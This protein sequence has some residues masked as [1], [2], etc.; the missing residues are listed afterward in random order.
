M[1]VSR[2]WLSG[3][4]KSSR[5]TSNWSRPSLSRPSASRDTHSMEK[6]WAGVS[7]SISLI[8]RASPGLSSTNRIRVGFVLTTYSLGR[9]HHHRQPEILDGLH[10]LDETVQVHRLG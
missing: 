5:T 10:H 8:R 4:P 1:R 7:A 2:P 9:Q 6:S 3:R